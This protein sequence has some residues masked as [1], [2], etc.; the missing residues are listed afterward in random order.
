MGPGTMQAGPTSA[1]PAYRYGPQDQPPPGGRGKAWLWVII[2]L[3]AVLLIGSGVY[4]L[5][6]A[7][8]KGGTISVPSVQGLTKA[9][10]QTAIVNA[11]LVPVVHKKHDTDVP[12]GQAIRT[13][14]PFGSVVAA[15]SKVTLFVSSGPGNIKV[16]DVTN[17]QEQAA[18]QTLVNDNFKVTTSPDPTSLKPAGTVVSQ[19]PPAGKSVKPGTT[20]HLVVSGGGVPVPSVI[21]QT[22]AAAQQALSAANLTSVVKIIP[23]PAGIEP[24]TVVSENPKPGSVVAAQTQITLTV[25]GA[26]TSTPTPTPTT[27]S[28]TTPPVSTPPPSTPPPTPDPEPSTTP[29]S[30]AP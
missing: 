13:N 24:G 17:Q 19:S 11:K 27:S 21:G 5:H 6:Y 10:A 20:V 30:P 4:A 2:G 23:D 28:P 8:S 7:S 22:Q 12:A 3:A 29:S 26:A 15:N 14:P 18:E 1:I 25:A 16:P 9:Q